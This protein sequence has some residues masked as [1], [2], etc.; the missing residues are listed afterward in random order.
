M[1]K[2]MIRMLLTLLSVSLDFSIRRIVTVDPA[3]I[4]SD[5]PGQEGCVVRGGLTKLLTDVVM[6]LMISCLKSHQARYTDPNK[7]M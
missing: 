6:L 5:N 4:T 1:L 2:N 7:R 3:L